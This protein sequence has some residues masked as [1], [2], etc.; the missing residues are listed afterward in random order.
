[1]RGKTRDVT[2]YPPGYERDDLGRRKRAET[3][4]VTVMGST[5]TPKASKS[6]TPTGERVDL[7][8]HVAAR[9]I[10]PDRDSRVDVEGF[11]EF[12]VL[13][14]SGGRRIWR[15][16]LARFERKDHSSGRV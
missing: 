2:F 12:T 14:V 9:D 16:D 10:T 13:S 3:E 11:G 5:T 1:M 7:V 15:L 8:V 4:G 6:T